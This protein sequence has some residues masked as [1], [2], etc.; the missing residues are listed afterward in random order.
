V[1]SPDGSRLASLDS[2]GNVYLG[3]PGASG[4]VIATGAL[5]TMPNSNRP[6]RLLWQPQHDALLYLASGA[7]STAAVELMPLGGK[8]RSLGEVSGLLDLSFSPDGAR[9]LLRTTQGFEIWNVAQPDKAVFSWT[10]ADPAALPW[11]SPASG[12]ILVQDSSSWQLVDIERRSV[13]TLITVPGATSTDIAKVSSWHPAAGSPWDATGNRFVFVGTSSALW[14]GK[15]ITAPHAG[16]TGLYV[17][18]L[19]SSHA[20]TLIDSGADRMPTWSYLDP[21]TAFLV[22]A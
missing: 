22:M 19:A 16:T 6:A 12:R 17:A 3:A 15:A 13:S 1:L 8:P 14:Q 11:W 18:D 5:L 20:P 10:E 2:K 21:S 9:L 7:Q 4:S